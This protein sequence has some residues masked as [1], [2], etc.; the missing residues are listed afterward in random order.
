MVA[1]SQYTCLNRFAERLYFILFYFILFY[2]ILFYF[3]LFYFILR[4]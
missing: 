1:K 4:A 2:F 3:I